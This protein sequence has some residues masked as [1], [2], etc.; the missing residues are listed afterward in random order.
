[1]GDA[2]GTR[3]GYSG[4]R[5]FARFERTK[6]TALFA[7]GLGAIALVVA[8]GIVILPLLATVVTSL[9][10]SVSLAF[11]P[12]SV[13]LKAY[14]SIPGSFGSALVTSLELGA[15]ATTLSAILCVPAATVLGRRRIRM[16][17]GTE[18]L[19]R[20]PIQVPPV[21]FGIAMY[22]YYTVL[23]AHK[24]LAL[25]GSFTGLLL[26]HVVLV[27]PFMYTAV[28][29]GA[30]RL[31]PQLEETAYS[32]G[33]NKSATF[34]RVVLP[35]L[36]FA[37]LAGAVLSFFASFDDVATTLF[38]V[39]PGRTTLPVLLYGYAEQSLSVVVYAVGTLLLM[40][41]FVAVAVSDRWLGIGQLE[42]RLRERK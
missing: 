5:S 11:P 8:V 2:H 7:N 23:E 28:S 33:A 31:T 42:A 36:R 10:T 39:G 37:V 12:H 24:I 25:R 35:Q 27:T 29:A 34:I 4:A 9:S 13:S 15:G 21:V 20:S 30:R 1:M 32:L 16:S 18:A 3:D 19:L 26:A 41:A 14:G 38:L 6:T 40:G 17:N 22:R